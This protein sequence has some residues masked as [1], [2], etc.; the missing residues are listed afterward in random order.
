MTIG[1]AEERVDQL[2]M[3]DR[4][5]HTA[6]VTTHGWKRDVGLAQERVNQMAMRDREADTA[7]VT[8]HGWQ[9]LLAARRHWR[10]RLALR[11]IALAGRIAPSV[12]AASTSA[13]TTVR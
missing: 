5:A 9:L 7:W 12:A 8:A 6:W 2:L 10:Q 1:L 4:Q 3:H 13:Q 11:L